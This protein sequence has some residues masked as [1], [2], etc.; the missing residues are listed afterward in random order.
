MKQWRQG[1]RVAVMT[2]AGAML[3]IALS[4]QAAEIA[5]TKQKAAKPDGVASR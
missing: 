5:A 1:A 3:S 2:V 4:G